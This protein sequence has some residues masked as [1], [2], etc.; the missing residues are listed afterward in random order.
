MGTE[1]QTG[2]PDRNAYCPCGSKKKYRKC[3]GKGKPSLSS[4]QKDAIH[5]AMIECTEH[6]RKVWIKGYKAIIQR[7]DNLPLYEHIDLFA[8]SVR[9]SVGERYPFI[10]K[11]GFEFYWMVIFSAILAAKTCAED[12]VLEAQK[13]IHEKYLG[14]EKAIYSFVKKKTEE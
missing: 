4:A 7:N 3:C 1:T 5:E 10:V 6:L 13:K 11:N 9:D 12:E 8:D 2:E 14:D